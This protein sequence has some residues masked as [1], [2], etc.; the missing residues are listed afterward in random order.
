M[1]PKQATMDYYFRLHRSGPPW[2]KRAD[3]VDWNTNVVGTPARFTALLDYP[4]WHPL[5][6]AEVIASEALEVPWWTVTSAL[7]GAY[8]M[9]GFVGHPMIEGESHALPLSTVLGV[10]R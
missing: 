7:D 4:V 5:T 9:A 2:P 8:V 6:Q 1:T 3:E 10:P